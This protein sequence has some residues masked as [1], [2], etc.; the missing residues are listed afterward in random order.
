MKTKDSETRYKRIW[1]GINASVTVSPG[2]GFLHKAGVGG[3]VIPHPSLAN[4]LLRLG[5]PDKLRRNLIFAHEFAHFRTVPVLFV[6]MLVL[7]ALFH[8]NGHNGIG[9]ILFLLIGG[10]AAW[11][12]MSEGLVILEDYAAYRSA[13]EG[14]KRFPEFFFGPQGGCLQVFHRSY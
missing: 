4:W 10:H 12:I 1:F 6:Y 2:S 13:Y 11:E 3:F 8:A 5:L 7:I 9:E 14:E